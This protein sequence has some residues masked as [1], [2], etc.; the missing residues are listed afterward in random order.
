MNKNDLNFN[1]KGYNF[2]KLNELKTLFFNSK[3]GNNIKVV[4][5]CRSFG[6]WIGRKFLPLSKIEHEDVID[7]SHMSDDLKYL[8]SKL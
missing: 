5:N 1:L 7:N 8:L 4:R 6:I 3:T 2:I